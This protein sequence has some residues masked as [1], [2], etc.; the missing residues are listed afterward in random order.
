MGA[1]QLIME[2]LLRTEELAIGYGSQ[3]LL[4][5]IVLD[6]RA[7]ELTALI[8]VNGIGKSTL[9]RTLAGLQA[10]MAGRVLLHDGVMRSLS[11]QQRARQVSIVLTGRPQGGMLDVA[12]L[13]ALGRQPWTNRWGS[14][15]PRDHEV[16]ESALK[17]AGATHLRDKSLDTCSDG[18]CQKVLIARALAQ[19]TPVMLLDEPTAFLDL[20][21]RADIVRTLRTIAREEKTAILFSTHDLQLAL[22]LC[23]RLILMRRDGPLW[24][25]TPAEALSSG[26]LERAFSGSGIR[27]DHANG[28]HR[29]MP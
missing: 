22:D 1:K 23:D 11:A 21:N 12:T 20:P 15:S 8:G 14:L 13:V 17:R 6:L 26:E 7:G 25:G 9:L 24:Q 29:F 16:V 28:T 4:K 19:S 5:D 18:E 10:P 27:F 3:P 2:P